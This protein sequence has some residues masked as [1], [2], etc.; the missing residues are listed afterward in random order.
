M[1]R[2]WM[3][4]Y[5][6]DY[7]SDTGHLTVT[8]H[9][10]YM[11]LIMHY[12][13]HGGLPA[14]ERL[15]ARIAR[16]SP[17]QWAESRD[18]LSMLFGPDWSHARIDEEISKADEIIGK[19]KAAAQGMHSKRRAKAVQVQSTCSDTRVPPF[20]LH[21]DLNPDGLSADAAPEP[22]PEI[23]TA[24]VISLPQPA[25][26]PR[27]DPV[28]ELFRDGLDSL[29]TLGVRE[30]QARRMLGKWRKDTGDD[31]RAVMAAIA[32]AREKGVSDPIPFITRVLIAK[33]RSSG[34]DRHQPHP[35]QTAFDELDARIA[36]Y[37]CH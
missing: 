35:L 4:L 15:I 21:Q 31:C 36:A 34:Y 20:T 2:P 17:D 14:D 3:P 32:L 27:P 33:S 13:K 22:E 7:L 19:R 1:I 37:G 28:A 23:M 10:A 5:V 11:L 16:L 26:S 9:G 12:W 29:M 8:E 18:V 30:P 6:D 24:E 25:P